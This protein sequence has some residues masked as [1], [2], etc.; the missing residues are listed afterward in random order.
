MEAFYSRNFVF[1]ILHKILELCLVFDEE[2]EFWEDMEYGEE[3]LFLLVYFIITLFQIL[4]SCKCF[5]FSF[6]CYMKE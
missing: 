1:D 3:F 6:S 5:F 2:S 4:H